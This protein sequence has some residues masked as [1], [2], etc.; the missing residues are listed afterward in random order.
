MEERAGII[1]Y[2]A[3]KYGVD[4]KFMA[5]LGMDYG[6]EGEPGPA[7]RTTGYGVG[8]DI[9]KQKELT[10]VFLHLWAS[11]PDHLGDSEAVEEMPRRRWAGGS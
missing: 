1:S 2:L 4:C 9:L 10:G 8:L 6:Q 7:T 3:D 5:T 11:E